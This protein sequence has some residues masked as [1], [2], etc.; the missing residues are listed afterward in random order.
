MSERDGQVRRSGVTRTDACKDLTYT[1]SHVVLQET[2]ERSLFTLTVA[3]MKG[4]H[5]QR[6][7]EGLRVVGRGHGGGRVDDVAI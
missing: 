6:A 3:T 1:C 7:D 5:G 4:V 2:M